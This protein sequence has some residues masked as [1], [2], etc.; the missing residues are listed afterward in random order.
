ML[1]AMDSTI[2]FSRSRMKMR[3]GPSGL[4][5]FDRRTGWNVLVDEVRIP[6]SQ[7][8]GAPRQ[9]SV[10]LTNACDLSCSYCY[11]PKTA[12][13]LDADRLTG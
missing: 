1:Q 4:H 2:R 9:I 12:A 5:F 3:A 11:A 6:P 7:W 8:A 10:A 13:T